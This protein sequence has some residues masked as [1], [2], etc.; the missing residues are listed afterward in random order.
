MNI[1]LSPELHEFVQTRVASGAYSSGGDVI[2]AAFALLNERERLVAEIDAGKRQLDSCEFT[3]YG[4][5][6]LPEFLKDLEA[7]SRRLATS[8]RVQ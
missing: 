3:E 2:R 8:K 6:S 5:Q 1:E 4:E 7:A